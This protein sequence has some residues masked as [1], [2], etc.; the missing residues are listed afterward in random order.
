MRKRGQNN[1]QP[2][3]ILNELSPNAKM[4]AVA[5]NWADRN[6]GSPG[7]AQPVTIPKKLIIDD[8]K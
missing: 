4:S 7:A 2:D 6:I 1:G 3:L 8:D 5:F